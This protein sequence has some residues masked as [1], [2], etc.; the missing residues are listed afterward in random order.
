MQKW[1]RYLL[2]IGSLTTCL[3]T[4][5]SPQ[6]DQPNQLSAREKKENWQLLFDGKT[7]TGWHV[8]NR[9][10][11][12]SAWVVQN[13]ELYCRPIFDKTEHGDLI[14]DQSFRNYDF[15]FEWKISA[16]G[17]SG[18]FINVR[19]QK[20]IP[21]AWASGP[22][23]QL[24][25]NSHPDYAISPTKRAGTLYGFYPPKNPVDPK[26]AGQWNQ[27]RIKQVDGKIEFYLNGV[28][29]AQEDLSSPHWKALVAKSNFKT[30]PHFGAYRQGHIALQDWSKGIAFRN[31]K[32]RSL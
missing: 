15:V 2:A 26:P 21:T 4:S 14:S 6:N 11:V 1:T 30:F 5:F 22:E 9:G 17:N 19:E 16:G 12:P 27:S 24:L 20:D 18:V 10:R 29:T 13:G 28:L 3:L 8:Y 32:I 7:L 23:Y 31:V 25:E